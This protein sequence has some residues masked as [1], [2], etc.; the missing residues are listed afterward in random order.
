[1]CRLGQDL[2]FCYLL[3]RE[4]EPVVVALH[5]PTGPLK[6]CSTKMRTQCISAQ[7]LVDKATATSDD[8]LEV[9]MRV[10]KVNKC[11]GCTKINLLNIMKINSTTPGFLLK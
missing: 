11:T 2:R 9:C 6:T 8:S 10:R 5:L 4:R 7:I 3:E 1:M